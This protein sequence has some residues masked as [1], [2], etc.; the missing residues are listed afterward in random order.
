M[1]VYLC[2]ELFRF[3]C[4]Q[5][6]VGHIRTCRHAR[7]HPCQHRPYSGFL[8]FRGVRFPTCLV[9]T[10]PQSVLRVVELIARGKLRVKLR[11]RVSICLEVAQFFTVVKK[12]QRNVLCLVR[13][14][15]HLIPVALVVVHLVLSVECRMCLVCP[16]ACEYVARIAVYRGSHRRIALLRWC[17]AE[18]SQHVVEEVGHARVRFHRRVREVRLCAIH[19]ARVRVSLVQRQFVHILLHTVYPHLRLQA[20]LHALH[21]VEAE[22]LYCI[23]R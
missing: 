8:V 12:L 4:R 20:L 11:V 13:H 22:V 17:R 18:L 23:F 7:L 9:R 6:C 15:R 16:R 3:P 2:F 10:A 5:V 21:P 14:A 1:T 19:L